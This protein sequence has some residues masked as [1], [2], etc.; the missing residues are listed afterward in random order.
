MTAARALF[1]EHG[2]DGTSVRDIAR[3]AGIDPA[4]V[5]RYFGSKDGL[6]A[7]T[8]E[9]QLNLPP[10]DR[11]GPDRIGETLVAHFLD[12]WDDE[13]SGLPV[14]LRSA[15]SNGAAS[16]RLQQ[17]FA[18]QV[19]PVILSVGPAENAPKRAALVASQILGLALTRYVLKLPPVVM[20]DRATIIAEVGATIQR[21]A[22]MGLDS[23]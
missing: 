16:D 5:I 1:R 21:Y 23:H 20:L 15:A 22:T 4:L 9:P 8:A 19:L 13:K 2:Y 3:D 6:F 18:G 17:V 14:L 12:V 10:L 11:D 7:A